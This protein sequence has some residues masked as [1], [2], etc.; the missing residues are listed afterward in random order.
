MG[1]F[2]CFSYILDRVSHFCLGL[3]LDQ[4]PPTYA[5]WVAGITDTGH[6]AWLICW[7]WILLA[8]SPDWPQA[9]VLLISAPE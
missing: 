3:A 1:L 2:F 9:A 6:H 8:F 7:D 4:F 5:S